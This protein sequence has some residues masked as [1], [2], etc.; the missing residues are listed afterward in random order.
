MAK[1]SGEQHTEGHNGKHYLAERGKQVSLPVLANE[2]DDEQGGSA[3]GDAQGVAA[4][5][6]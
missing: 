5:C 2:H 6:R 4:R 3:K 1:Y